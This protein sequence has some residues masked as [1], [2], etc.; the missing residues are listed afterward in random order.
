MGE[1][2]PQKH[3]WDAALE[4]EPHLLLQSLRSA[5]DYHKAVRGKELALLKRSLDCHKELSSAGDAVKVRA[6]A[7]H[8]SS[9]AGKW[10]CFDDN[11]VEAWD[12]QNLDK[13]CFGGKYNIDLQG[14]GGLKVCTL[15]LSFPL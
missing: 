11:T 15:P 3:I 7:G 13:D 2:C 9:N 4:W 6:E 5:L 1:G 8:E 12:I 14:M 10:F